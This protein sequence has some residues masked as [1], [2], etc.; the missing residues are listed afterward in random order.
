[1]IILILKTSILLLITRIH[2]FNRHPTTDKLK[3]MRI[4]LINRPKFC[5][6]IPRRDKR[7][8]LVELKS[9]RHTQIIWQLKGWNLLKLR[10]KILN[11]LQLNRNLPAFR[12]DNQMCSEMKI[13]LVLHVCSWILMNHIRVN[14]HRQVILR[15]IIRH[16]SLNYSQFK[17]MNNRKILDL[18]KMK[19]KIVMK[20]LKR[21]LS[22]SFNKW[23][24]KRVNKTENPSMNN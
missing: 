3:K 22:F 12:R 18:T 21:N 1:M 16:L 7:G 14:S 19:I 17:T 20:V 13:I 24:A 2:W 5:T 10:P 11:H 4:L 9:C 23:N 8:S 15:R 6:M